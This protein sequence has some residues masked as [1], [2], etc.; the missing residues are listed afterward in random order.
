[1]NLIDELIESGKEG[2]IV[3]EPRDVFDGAVIGYDDHQ[4]RLIYKYDLLVSSLAEDNSNNNCYEDGHECYLMAVEWVDYNTL[5][6]L[7]YMGEYRP[8]VMVMNEDGELV[9][10]EVEND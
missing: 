5:R 4:N 7:P 1:M 8:I 3:L 9:D 2:F 10:S 6:S